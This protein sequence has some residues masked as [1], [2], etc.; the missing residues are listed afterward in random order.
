MLQEAYSRLKAE[1]SGYTLTEEDLYNMYREREAAEQKHKEQQW[2]QEAR[3]NMYQGDERARENFEKWRKS[4]F[5][6]YDQ[7]QHDEFLKNR[8]QKN[9]YKYTSTQY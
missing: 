5:T 6:A 8:Y 4:Q 1:A 2:E 7:A 3:Q 9:F